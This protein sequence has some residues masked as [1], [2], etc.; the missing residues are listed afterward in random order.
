MNEDIA[1]GQTVLGTMTPVQLYAGE[2]PI[3]TGDYEIAAGVTVVK[4]G[5]YALDATGKV[6]VWDPA[7]TAPA[8]IPKVVASQAGVAGDRIAFFEGGYF[9]HAA[10]VWPGSLTTFEPRRAAFGPT[11]SIKIGRVTN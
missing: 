10:L 7:G 11:G 3:V 1:S 2:A 5:V 8:T 6:I 9:N 4:Y